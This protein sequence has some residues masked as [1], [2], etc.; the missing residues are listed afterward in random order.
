MQHV[1]NEGVESSDLVSRSRFIYKIS[2]IKK[3]NKVIA[4]ETGDILYIPDTYLGHKLSSN[5]KTHFF[6]KYSGEYY[7]TDQYGWR[8]GSNDDKT[9][10]KNIDYFICG[11]S[12]VLGTGVEY[13]DTIGH[14]LSKKL[15]KTIANLGVGNYSDIQILRQIDISSKKKNPKLVIMILEDL[16]GRSFKQL[17]TDIVHRPFFK[18]N[19]KTKKFELFESNPIPFFLYK[20]FINLKKKSQVKNLNLINKLEASL[21]FLCFQFLNNRVKNF[22]LRLIGLNNYEYVSSKD[23]DARLF[24]LKLIS[25]KINQ[26]VEKY[27]YNFFIFPVYPYMFEK[28]RIKLFYKEVELLSKLISKESNSDKIFFN[29]SKDLEKA[30]GN[31][32]K[33]NNIKMGEF[34]DTLLWSDNNH[35]TPKGTKIYADC[36]YKSLIKF[37]LI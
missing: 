20:R 25:K 15:N 17:N 5:T 24:I 11:C 28:K 35:P 29:K 36:I 8:V 3:Y 30:H 31:F 14:L 4:S 10:L 6:R 1:A 22:L 7:F 37:K 19:K 21:L 23:K 13:K 18:K 34:I 12:T 9:N 33:K 27:N 32:F 2:M 16:I 26:L